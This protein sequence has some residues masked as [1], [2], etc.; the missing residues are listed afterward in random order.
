VLSVR[1]EQFGSPESVW[2][3]EVKNFPVVVAIDSHGNNLQQLVTDK[4]REALV[5]V[6]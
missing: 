2:E 6:L 1:L 4:S 5:A 3:F